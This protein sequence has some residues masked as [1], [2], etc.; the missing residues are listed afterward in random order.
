KNTWFAV[1]C[2]RR[3]TAN[4]ERISYGERGRV[5]DLRDRPGTGIRNLHQPHI[6][7]EVGAKHD[8]I[9]IPRIGQT[10][11]DP[12][13]RNLATVSTGENVPVFGNDDA[14]PTCMPSIPGQP[15]LGNQSHG[16]VESDFLRGCKV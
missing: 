14:A 4:D 5:N 1:C 8:A 7:D 11:R 9:E 2:P 10:Y 3:V 6:A 12:F 16:R 15:R 13:T